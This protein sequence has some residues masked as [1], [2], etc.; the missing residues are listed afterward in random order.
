[1]GLVP[2]VALAV[3]SV[4]ACQAENSSQDDLQALL[5]DQ[6][7]TF[8][9]QGALGAPAGGSVGTMTGAAGA[10][11]DVDAGATGVGGSG[12][13]DV[14]DGGPVM[15]GGGGFGGGVIRDAGVGGFAGGIGDGGFGGF[16]GTPFFGPLGQWS[17]DDCNSF[18][19]NLG[20]SG[21]NSNTAFRSVG[22]TCAPGI[23]NQAVS[24]AMKE[25][26]VYVPDQPNFTFG[27]G[28]TVAAWFNPTSTNQTR[29]LF[30]K[31]DKGTSS[32]ALVLNGGKFQFVINLGDGRAASVV[33]PK[34]AKSGVFQHV[35]GTYDG[36]MLSLYVD[37]L[38]VASLNVY[39]TIPPGP[40][41]L[42]M[43][44][45][46]SERRF[47]G[48]ID[49]A[50]FD[51][52]ALAANEV[53]AL[54]CVPRQPTMVTTPHTSA[55]TPANVP[56]SFDIAVTNNSSAT[57]NPA[58]F[59]F[60]QFNFSPGITIDPPPFFPSFSP[61]VPSGETTHF[62][63]TATADDTVEPGSFFL[64]FQVFSF[65]GSNSFSLFDTVE[66]V[67]A[68]PTGCHVATSRELMIKNLSVVD[69]P[70]RTQF[71]G[72]PDDPRTGVWT[73]KHLMESMAPT[74]GDAPS[75]VEDM[76]KTFT[77]TQ[78]INGFT[79][80]PR[81]GMQSL[82]LNAWPRTADGQLDL[83][84]APLQL[85]A[86]VN[87]FDL[88]NP[89][90]G[91][92]GE[93]RFVFA[94][95]GPGR[96]SPLQATMIFE[97]KLPAADADAVRGWADAW[98]NLGSMQFSEDY[99]VAL[100]AITERFAGRGAR[101][102]HPNGSAINAVRTNEIDFSDNGIW[103]LREFVLSPD[104]GRLVPATIKLTPDRSFNNTGTLASFINDN[105]A[106]IIAE[107]HTVPDQ[108][109]GQPFLGGAVFNDL[110]T[111]FAP[112]INNN[113]ARF[114]FA[115]NTCNGCHSSQETGV[116]FLQ[117]TPRFPGG[118][119]AGLSPFLTGTTVSDPVTGLPRQF[120]ELGR[121]NDVLTLLECGTVAPPPPPPPITG[122]GGFGGGGTGGS[123][124]SFG[125]A[126]A[127][128]SGMGSAGSGGTFPP[129]P[130][131]PKTP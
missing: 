115:V 127:G 104:T 91:D 36:T 39:G 80:G 60:Q 76:L 118:G 56:A 52:R 1:M 65:N 10:T 110:T 97:Y 12:G 53:L 85:Q 124:G 84:Q 14:P 58:T 74:P 43:G 102:D 50:F 28:V 116:F 93:G 75:M 78:T 125:G 82:I 59:Q 6:D 96:F 17:F 123:G 55:P 128:V 4:V 61:P 42:L 16:G 106:S 8:L 101:P 71:V 130:P 131:P 20:D 108:L 48:L 57:C 79:V 22:V 24:L 25:D 107:T 3:A 31:R 126:D 9:T 38:P 94:F 64:S 70:V 18:R 32:F 77:T 98:H 88:N 5:K 113:E 68:E 35:A 72:A 45:D 33:A 34:K 63:M 92:A 23:S 13:G 37:G 103:Q 99:N 112:G 2:M 47:D 95:L 26:I 119:E 40:G 66:F 41:P 19:T 15:T 90:A 117:I 69:D 129:P 30:R 105:E 120:R 51:G 122:T 49:N 54:T 121:R 114:H 111:W 109:N 62:T 81:P 83:T 7:L 21:P 11:G 73:F 44:N 86:I 46:G 67:V 87:R 29:T 100:Q 27:N 89:A